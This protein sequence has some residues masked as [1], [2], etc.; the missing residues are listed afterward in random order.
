MAAGPSLSIPVQ[1]SYSPNDHGAQEDV[2]GQA[3]MFD[4]PSVDECPH[5]TEDGAKWKGKAIDDKQPRASPGKCRLASLPAELISSILSYLSPYDLVRVSK[6]CR[7]IREH[8]LADH[9]WQALV[10]D[11]VP[12]VRVTSPY[13]CHTFRDLFREHDPH[14]FLPKYKIWFSDT[15]LPGRLIIVRYD[16]RRGCIEG[17]QLLA[18]KKS[19]SFHI[20]EAYPAITIH[21][22]DPLVKLHLDNPVLKLTPGLPSE[23]Y[24]GRYVG[25]IK[26]IKLRGG[27]NDSR[28]R[29]RFLGEIPMQLGSVENMRN[30]FMYAR[31][32]EPAEIKRYLSS[33][34]PYGHIWPPPAVPS[35]HRVIGN[36]PGDTYLPPLDR[37]SRPSCRTELCD[38]AFRIRKWIELRI[39]HHTAG[40]RFAQHDPTGRVVVDDAGHRLVLSL[41]QALS[42]G[43]SAG[44]PAAQDNNNNNNGLDSGPDAYNPHPHPHFDPDMPFLPL[45]FHGDINSTYATLDPALYTPTPEKPYQGIWVGDYSGHGCEF[46]W[47]HHPDDEYRPEDVFLMPNTPP[48]SPRELGRHEGESEEEFA[49]RRCDETVHQGRLVAVKL[50]GDANVPRGE[51]TWVVD[52]LGEG[53]FVKVEHEPPFEGV[54]VVRSK[55]HVANTGFMNDRYIDTH[56]FLISPD[57]L[58]Q[59]WIDF[60]HISFYQRVDIDRF[61]APE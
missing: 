5:A 43:E 29:S 16:Q 40:S 27:S 24:E 45:G 2:A 21:S 19:R 41:N 37:E 35:Q 25:D 38:R 57:R 12:G 30:N 51:Y 42:L 9:L 50:T 36:G 34:F 13:P 11:H 31:T 22:F 61:L 33:E 54:R 23:P 6:T 26:T 15:D 59:H 55:G 46:L 32:L 18:N 39:Y 17:Y 48:D 60:G 10:Q 20:W 28:D 47:V 14:W 58:A 4:P 1:G 44:G 7:D 8:A 49:K 52:D 3:M 56:L 53:G